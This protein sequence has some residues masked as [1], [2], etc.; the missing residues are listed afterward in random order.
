MDFFKRLKL[1]FDI[2][3]R[4]K[5]IDKMLAYGVIKELVRAKSIAQSVWQRHEEDLKVYEEHWDDLHQESIDLTKKLNEYGYKDLEDYMHNQSDDPELALWDTARRLID[6]MITPEDQEFRDQER[7]DLNGEINAAQK[8]IDDIDRL[9]PAITSRL[10]QPG[11]KD[12]LKTSEE[13]ECAYLFYME[14]LIDF[15]TIYYEHYYE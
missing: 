6:L 5:Y 3:F 10:P 8:V 7:A 14:N 15:D 1:R 9:L 13:L 12:I 11:Y 2:A 4:P